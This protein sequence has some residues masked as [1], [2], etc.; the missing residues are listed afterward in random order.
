MSAS[1]GTVTPG[2]ARCCASSAVTLPQEACIFSL[3]IGANLYYTK[4]VMAHP[5]RFS[6]LSNL[7]RPTPSMHGLLR[8]HQ[9]TVFPV[10]RNSACSQ[11]KPRPQC[12]GKGGAS[13]SLSSTHFW[14]SKPVWK[15]AGINTLRCLVGCTAGD[16]SAMWYLQSFHA[17]LGLSTIM[18]LSSM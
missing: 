17:D 8:R 14:D 3:K 7:L 12:S 18:A 9:T 11:N 15:R 5:V 10:Q 16:F 2:C 4:L 1:I 13:L 6:S